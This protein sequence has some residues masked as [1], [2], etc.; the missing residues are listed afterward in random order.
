MSARARVAWALVSWALVA[1]AGTS[2]CATG[3]EPPTDAGA[4]DEG[5]LIA[6]EALAP[7]DDA[8]PLLLGA[9]RVPCVEAGWSVEGDSFEVNTD[10]CDPGLFQAPTLAQLD[11]GDRVSFTRWHL[12]L[13]AP[14]PTTG[15][16]A[17]AIGDEVVWSESFSIPADEDVLAVEEVVTETHPAGTAVRLLVENHGANS[18]RFTSLRWRRAA[19]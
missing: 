18:Y 7:T 15:A 13:D 12:V 17:L 19:P 10:A 1:C 8:G 3:A 4:P 6:L 2:S 11:A 5:S 16:M 14:L 9:T